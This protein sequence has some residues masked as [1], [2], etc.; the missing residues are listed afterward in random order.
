M[1]HPEKQKAKKVPI[2]NRGISTHRVFQKLFTRNTEVLQKA[3]EITYNFILHCI[4]HKNVDFHLN[5]AE[6][7]ALTSDHFDMVRLN[8]VD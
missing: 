6:D 2:P 1:S 4:K 3:F 8:V 7:H 5:R